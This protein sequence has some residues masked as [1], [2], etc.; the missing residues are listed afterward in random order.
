M[1]A[2]VSSTLVL[3]CSVAAKWVLPEPDR[4]QA[5]LLLDQYRSG[6]IS[7]IAPDLL[8][9]EFASLLAKRNRRR[10]ISAEQAGQAFQLMGKCVP[11]VLDMRP[12]IPFAL[13]LSLRY[14]LSLWDC[15]YLALAVEYDCPFLTADRRLFRGTGRRHPLI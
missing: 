8:L 15:V 5:L 4:A 13:D 6:E 1:T 9:A 12:R 3:D 11:R 14:Q 7:L 10:E 2:A